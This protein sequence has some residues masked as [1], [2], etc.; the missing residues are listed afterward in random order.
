M[1]KERKARDTTKSHQ[2][3]LP[4]RV[5]MI[6]KNCDRKS[7]SKY[8]N[9]YCCSHCRRGAGHSEKCNRAYQG[10]ET[11]VPIRGKSPP[12]SDQIIQQRARFSFARRSSNRPSSRHGRVQLKSAEER[13][14]RSRSRGRSSNRP[15]SRTVML[16]IKKSA[17]REIASKLTAD[18]F[19]A[20]L[21]AYQQDEEPVEPITAEAFQKG[22]K[23]GLHV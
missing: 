6:C 8:F 16:E 10:D 2:I 21:D 15:S 7:E 11:R 18:E 3:I 5:L 9:E 14:A 4:T 17:A 13:R 23:A 1:A 12:P 22:E 20:E 19:D